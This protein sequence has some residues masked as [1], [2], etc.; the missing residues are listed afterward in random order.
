MG[1]KSESRSSFNAL[2]PVKEQAQTLDRHR[3]DDGR[4]LLG[5]DVVERLQVAQLQRRWRLGDNLG[6]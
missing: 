1:L 3:E 2:V 4:I 6:R 5:R